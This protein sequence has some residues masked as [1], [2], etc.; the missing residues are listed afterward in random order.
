MSNPTP[1]PRDL[2]SQLAIVKEMINLNPDLWDVL[3]AM[4]GPDRGRGEM[5]SERPCDESRPVWTR[6]YQARVERKMVTSAVVRGKAFGSVRSARTS[7]ADHVVLPPRAMWDH[8]DKHCAQAAK[9]LGLAIKE[10]R[11]VESE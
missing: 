6:R 8:F 10:V 2:A 4:R 5:W 3:V 9:A 1:P 7:H 11:E